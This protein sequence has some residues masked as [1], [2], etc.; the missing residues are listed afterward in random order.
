MKLSIIIPV[1]NENKTIVQ[2][3]NLVEKQTYIQKQII[4]VDDFSSDNS[5]QLIENFKFFSDHVILKHD[6]N[7]GKGACIKTAKKVIDGDIVLIQDAD[8]E[9][10]PNDYKKL[11]HPII[12]QQTNVV[13][14][15]R[16]LGR[17]RYTNK[18]FTSIIRIFANHVLTIISNYFNDQKLT[19][20]HT[21]Y[22]VCKKNIF[23]K[24]SLIEDDFAFCPELTCK[25]AFLNEKIIEVP[26]EYYGRSYD[27]GKKIKFSDGL[28]ALYAIFRHK[29]KK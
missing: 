18:N 26:I 4:I 14:G 21:C 19:D 9:Y 29:P 6:V 7:R 2:L 20:A 22:K 5:L 28:K 25:I 13:Y 16:V 15:S 10:N 27:D 24:L 17:E 1:F 12:S 23:D 11:I 8:L 3:L